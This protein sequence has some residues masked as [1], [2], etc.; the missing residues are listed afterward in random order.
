MD[1]QTKLVLNKCAELCERVYSD[2][3]DYVFDTS[4][5]GFQIFAVEG[6]KE[7]TDW[8]TNFKFLFRNNGMHRGFKSNAERTLVESIASG[9]DFDDDKTLVLTGHSLGGAT[10]ACLADLLQARFSDLIL[11]TF[12]SP[13]PGGRTLRNRIKDLEQYRYRHGN[14]IVPTTPPYLA[15]YIHPSPEINLADEDAKMFDRVAD[16]NVSD[17][18]KQL[19]KLLATI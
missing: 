1:A 17:Y 11:V 16:H 7:K 9:H 10:A 18:R 15:G 3:L 8:I 4:I 12:G 6:T 5:P 19:A 2:E 13:R 14:D